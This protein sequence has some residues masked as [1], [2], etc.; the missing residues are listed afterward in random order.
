MKKLGIYYRY[1]CSYREGIMFSN[2]SAFYAIFN[3]NKVFPDP[4]S[5]MRFEKKEN[6]EKYMKLRY[7]KGYE[8][9][10]VKTEI[11]YTEA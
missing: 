2:T 8:V 6:A 9:K 11:D 10:H 4:I 1:P 3:K 7:G 5:R